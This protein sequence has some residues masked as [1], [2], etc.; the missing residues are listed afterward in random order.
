[1]LSSPWTT[2]K[3][4]LQVKKHLVFLATAVEL[5]GLSHNHCLASGGKI[6]IAE[7]SHKA[8]DLGILALKISYELSFDPFK[9]IFLD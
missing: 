4:K 8:E 9:Y 2:S 3:P 5:K 1:M 6:E 7:V